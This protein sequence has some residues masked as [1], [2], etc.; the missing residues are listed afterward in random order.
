[1]L[2]QVSSGKWQVNV[3][4]ENLEPLA[5]ELDRSGNRLSLSIV[6]AAIVVGSSMVVTSDTE[7]ELLG[8]RLQSYGFFGY[9]FAGILGIGL[10]W[11]IL[12]SGR[13]S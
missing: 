9:L 3:R 8:I 12:R 2:R 4:H 13:L 11:A 1:M 5:R 7:M 10:L 6:I